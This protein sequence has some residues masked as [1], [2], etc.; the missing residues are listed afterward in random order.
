MKTS[1]VVVPLG[2][3]LFG[4]EP[5][6][7][8]ATVLVGKEICLHG[9]VPEIRFHPMPQPNGAAGNLCRIW[10]FGLGENGLARLGALL[11][12]VELLA[13]PRRKEAMKGVALWVAALKGEA[14]WLRNIK[15]EWKQVVARTT[16]N[17]TFHVGYRLLGG[18]ELGKAVEDEAVK[19]VGVSKTHVTVEAADGGRRRLPILAFARDMFVLL[20]RP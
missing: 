17:R 5:D 12:A 13:E 3:D 4:T 20:P 15:P 14:A 11:H 7:F 19:L 18:V 6:S 9:T 16:V 8:R 1:P 2:R 10:L